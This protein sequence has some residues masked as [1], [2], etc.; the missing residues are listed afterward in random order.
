MEIPSQETRES[1]NLRRRDATNGVPRAASSA[2]PCADCRSR[3]GSIL[4]A[5]VEHH[6]RGRRRPVAVRCDRHTQCA[7]DRPDSECRRT[8]VRR[9]GRFSLNC[10]FGPR[11]E[12][13]AALTKLALR[14][15]A[16]G[17]GLRMARRLTAA[18]EPC[19]RRAVGASF[20]DRRSG[21]RMAAAA[22]E[23]CQGR[24]DQQHCCDPRRAHH[25]Q[26]TAEHGPGTF[27]G[28]T[29]PLLREY[30][31]NCWFGQQ[32]FAGLQSLGSTQLLVLHRFAPGKP[33][34]QSRRTRGRDSSE[35]SHPGR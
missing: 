24:G 3:E 16:T 22:V 19:R 9:C 27:C 23:R 10:P 2:M 26:Q 6:R 35:L 33:R 13:D 29:H 31:V 7:G 15:L 32:V 25:M 17:L 30:F 1:E 14:A 11:D 8:E 21:C 28:I 5:A 18:A 4:P 20:I 12:R 34:R